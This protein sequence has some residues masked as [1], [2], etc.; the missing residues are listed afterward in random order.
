KVVAWGEGNGNGAERLAERKELL[1]FQQQAGRLERAVSGALGVANETAGR[2]EQIKRALDH[3]P[4]PDTRWKDAGRALEGRN[5]A[6]LRAL[7]GDVALRARQENTPASIQERL[8]YALG[9]H[10][11]SLGRPTATQRESYR[12]ASAEFTEQLAKLRRLVEVDLK[13]LEKGLD[14]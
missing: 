4:G 3:A 1:E 14:E 8:R 10:R 2:V 11:F 5:R 6:I 9:S 13:A 12:V 7:R